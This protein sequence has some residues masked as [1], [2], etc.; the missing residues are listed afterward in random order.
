MFKAHLLRVPDTSGSSSSISEIPAREIP[1]IPSVDNP[2]NAERP[3]DELFS[4]TEAPVRG[5]LLERIRQTGARIIQNRGITFKK[6][7]GR[8]RKDGTPSPTD[9]VIDAPPGFQHDQNPVTFNPASPVDQATVS[10]CRR[11]I[12][13]LVKAI[14]WIAKEVI[15]IKADAASI[16][17]AFTEKALKKA[18][19][20]P[21]ALEDFQA[22]LDAVLNKH[23]F[24]PENDE[25][26]A[27]AIDAGRLFAPYLLLLATFNAEISRK[28][29]EQMERSAA[30][31]K[32]AIEA[33]E[34]ERRA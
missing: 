17:P 1:S 16:D 24:K 21:K 33:R 28:R 12:V 20:D 11:S 14:D 23:N 4:T 19:P 13:A 3:A 6:G 25:E 26:W 5:S 9:E 15:R 27:L 34:N 32:R 30:E 22:S 2:D 8:P 7:R 10:L 31:N 29:L 18:E